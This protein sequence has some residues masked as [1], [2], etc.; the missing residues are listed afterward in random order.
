MAMSLIDRNDLP[1]I[2]T[3]IPSFHGRRQINEMA[4]FVRD[5]WVCVAGLEGF[6]FGRI[7]LE[8]L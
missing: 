5:K 7:F 2:T 4:G 6:D 3:M 1:I 8:M